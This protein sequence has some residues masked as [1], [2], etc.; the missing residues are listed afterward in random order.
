MDCLTP[1]QQL[2]YASRPASASP[3]EGYLQRH[4]EHQL[5]L[6]EDALKF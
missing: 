2:K 5:A 4:L 1:K 3:A 6:I